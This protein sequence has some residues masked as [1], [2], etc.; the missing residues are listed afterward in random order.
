MSVSPIVHAAPLRATSARIHRTTPRRALRATAA[1]AAVIGTVMSGCS[2]TPEDRA[3]RTSGATATITLVP[4]TTGTSPA[5]ENSTVT[6]PTAPSSTAG[7]TT[8]SFAPPPG[9]VVPF[10]TVA[11]DSAVGKRIGLVAPTGSDPFGKAVTESVVAQV[12][13]AGAELIRCDPGDNPTLVLDCAR[14]MATEHVDGWIV[15]QPGDLGRALCDIGPKDVPLIAIAAAP[16]GCQS[17]DVGADD[18]QAGFLIGQELGQASR[19]HSGCAHDAFIIVTNSAAATVST[20]R[21]EGIRAGFVTRCPGPIADEQILDAG[22]QDRAYHAF[23]TALT[24]APDDA[25]ILVAAVNDAAALGVVAAIPDSRADHI[26]VAA[27]GADERA[28]CGMV[29]NPRWIGDA[30]LFPDRYGDVAVP[31]LLDAIHGQEVLPAM[32]VQTTFVT[33]RTIS[34]FYDVRDC[35]AR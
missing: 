4:T 24:A 31:A 14:R 28:R 29:A 18:Q 5:T 19:S 11:A 20:Q 17:A 25:E 3:T 10:R 33:A 26:T 16:I 30:A 32:Y 2:G 15:V 23:T 13:T 22:T 1:I 7:G 35:P 9:T 21:I 34:D 12:K 8:A 27:I 6:A